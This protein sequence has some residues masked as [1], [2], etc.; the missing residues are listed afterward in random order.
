MYDDITTTLASGDR[1]AAVDKARAAVAAAPDDAQAH[2]LL[3]LALALTGDPT[4]AHASLDRALHLAPHDALLHYQ[5]AVLLFGEERSDEASAELA[6][7]MRLDPNHLPAYVMQAQIALAAANVDEA[8]RLT[9]LAARIDPEHPWLLTIQGL[10]ALH[11]NDAPRAHALL[12]RAVQLAPGNIQARYALGQAYMAQGHLAFAEEA[13]RQ[14]VERNPG[15]VAMRQMLADVVRRQGRPAEAADLLEPAIAGDNA[16]PDLLRYAGELRLVAQDHERALPLLRRAL[17]G[18]PGDG[19]IL[20][21]LIEALRRKGDQADARETIE[22]ALQDTPQIEGLWSARLFFEPFDGDPQGIIERWRAALPHSVH[23]LHAAMSLAA[24][25][26]KPDDAEAIARRIL[27][28]EPGHAGAQ[29]Q[30]VSH[31]FQ[32]APAQAVDYIASL[33]P[34]ISDDATLRTVRGWLAKSQDRAGQHAD[35]LATWTALHARQADTVPLP[36]LTEGARAYP[37]LA[38]ADAAEPRPVFVYGLPGSGVER[39]ATVLLASQ[40]SFRADRVG[41]EPPADP[42]Q[43][44][45]T[46]T[47]LAAG[48]VDPGAVVAG[49]KAALPGRNIVDGRVTDWLAWWDNALLHALRPHLPQARL[50]LVLRDPRDMLLDWLASGTYRLY[51]VES[52]MAIARWLAGQLDQVAT[53]VE[54]DLF[55]YYVLRVDANGDDP[56]ALAAAVGEALGS[57]MQAPQALGP[58]RYPAGHW[59]EYRKVL[60]EPF[61]LLADGARRLGYPA[62]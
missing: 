62:T 27:D 18:A 58:A 32:T 38:T 53:L 49:W 56:A 9:R 29:V 20:D 7:T 5:R 45:A 12:Q 50:L 10:V 19:P 55:P 51:A 31:L 42:L 60:A 61:A 13:F 44:P 34:N 47:A 54:Q 24:T 1:A 15:A 43:D 40:P 14:V 17:A 41:P 33:L 39:V 2:R 36:A 21:S 3:G 6:E 52:P 46:A 57:E 23:A 59:R 30:V 35:A 26:G 28:V 37:P 22:K 25:E 8:D 11:R 16:L 48:K 4:G